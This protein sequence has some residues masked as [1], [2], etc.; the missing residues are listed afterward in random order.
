M[1]ICKEAAMKSLQD[2][3]AV[4]FFSRRR[5]VWCYIS[6]G[7]GILAL[8]L[9]PGAGCQMR[10]LSSA[11][12]YVR[13]NQ[14]DKAVAALEE[15][16]AEHPENAEAQFLLGQ[17]YAMQ[18]RF[19]E[20]NRAFTAS[21]AASSQFTLEIKS[22]RQKYFSENFNAGIKAVAADNFSAAA[23]AFATAAIIDSSQPEVYRHLAY[24]HI[25]LGDFEKAGA[26][27]QNLLANN[28]ADWETALA[29][30]NL[31]RQQQ[32]YEKSA[33]MLERALR[34]NP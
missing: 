2:N 10:E 16:V 27:Y 3:R 31:Y 33:A 18:K 30:A 20:M 21:L 14:W 29:A 28:P 32:E 5:F 34:Q 9:L 13:Q 17:G 11:K 15:A 4:R 23:E 7:W 25:Q 1:R 26:L 19:A 24:V 22:W 12:V 6:S 8:V